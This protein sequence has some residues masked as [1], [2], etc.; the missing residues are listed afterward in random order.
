MTRSFEKW[1]FEATWPFQVSISVGKILWIAWKAKFLLGLF[2]KINIFSRK[3]QR[4]NAPTP[5]KVLRS[6]FRLKLI[7][8]LVS[9][10]YL[11]DSAL[12]RLHRHANE[13]LPIFTN[14]WDQIFVYDYLS[15][16]AS[17]RWFFDDNIHYSYVLHSSCTE[18]KYSCAL[19]CTNL[20]PRV[21]A[22]FI[23]E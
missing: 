4:E 13:N 19:I 16:I 9:N 6:A 14:I 23:R 7:S 3:C 22:I 20:P 15:N 2:L 1:P 10:V 5:V 12:Q 18:R 21:R 17:V 8:G 11:V